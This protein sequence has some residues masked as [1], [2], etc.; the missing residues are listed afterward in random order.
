VLIVD[1]HVSAR[2]LL[3]D[4]VGGID[5]FAVVGEAASGEE[6]LQAAAALSPRLVIMDRRMPGIDGVEAS[7]ELTARHPEITVVLI[8]ADELS[9]QVVASCGAASFID[10]HELSRRGLLEAWQAHVR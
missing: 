5:G 2:E 1:D 7:R 3:R 6:A 9:P 10:K 4:L 8:S